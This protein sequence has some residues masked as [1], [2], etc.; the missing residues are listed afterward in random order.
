MR[1]KC[2]AQEHN[3]MSPARARTRTARSGNERTNHDA[4]APPFCGDRQ[5]II[6]NDECCFKQPSYVASRNKTSESVK[7]PNNKRKANISST[8]G[9]EVCNAK[10]KKIEKNKSKV[11]LKGT[12]TQALQNVTK[13]VEILPTKLR[14]DL[15]TRK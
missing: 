15:S 6:A 3:A 7:V 9:D 2:L 14:P 4:T 11:S 8:K 13:S 5:R 12:V 10:R 1:V